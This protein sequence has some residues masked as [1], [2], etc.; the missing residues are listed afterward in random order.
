MEQLG[1]VIKV[2]RSGALATLIRL[3][4][5]FDL[6]EEAVQEATCRALVD[7]RHNGVA[8]NPVAWLVQ[9]GRRYAIDTLRHNAMARQHQR[10]L[11]WP[12]ETLP[13]HDNDDALSALHLPD[14]QLRLIFVCCHPALAQEAQVALTLKT[15]AGLGVDEIA[16][17][18]LSSPKTIE[19]RLTRAKRKIRSA[20]IAYQVPDEDQLAGRLDAVMRVLYLIYNQA[21]TTLTGPA[22]LD[23]RLAEAA[24]YLARVL[25]R[26]IRRHAEVQGLLALMLLQHARAAA[27]V[28]A[29][30]MPVPL[31]RQERALWDAK[32]I[33]E[34]TAMVEKCLRRGPPGPYGLQAAIAAVH[35][36]ASSAAE[37][38]WTEIVAL[39]DLL[40]AM[41]P[42]PVVTLNRAVAVARVQ[43]AGAGLRILDAFGEH[44]NLL[45]FQ[46]YHSARAGLLEEL[47]EGPRALTAYRRALALC[48]NDAES[49]YLSARIERLRRRIS[50]PPGESS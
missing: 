22:L 21:Y 3:L 45:G 8:D 17:A 40:E 36:R 31:E 41:S 26:L 32:L 50:V 15:V 2:A 29:G 42:N 48:R 43:G 19:Q 38:D 24:I 35:C 18:Y 14:D 44:K 33:A 28:D 49:A 23:S 12:Q 11:L 4:G 27:R 7:W 6:A 46:Y 13:A 34:G 1:L 25:N 47:G 5:D 20:V 30:G 9:T 39:Y 16:R 37:T 10:K